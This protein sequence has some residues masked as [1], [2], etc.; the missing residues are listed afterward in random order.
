[1]AATT[2]SASGVVTLLALSLL[3]LACTTSDR[4]PLPTVDRLDLDRFMGD[5]YVVAS[6]PTRL[7]RGAHNAVESYRLED[8][9]RVAT[10]FTFREG[11]FDG[12]QKR[13]TPTGF[14]RQGTGNAVWG[15]QFI[16]P[17][18]AEYRVMHVDPDYRTTIIGRTKRDYVW[19]M[20]REPHL[21][22]AELEAL[23]DRAVDAGYPR[24][25]IVRV[26]QRWEAS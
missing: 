22:E 19:I 11:A 5:W 17:I 18:K 2:A 26:P 23:I 8:D 14:V 24:D 1:M 25:E 13:F 7:E 9:G 15:M 6:I 3:M 12:P 4:P 10:T 20:A 16:W 21:P